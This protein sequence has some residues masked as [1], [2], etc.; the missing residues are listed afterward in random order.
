MEQQAID[1]VHR[2]G[3]R[4]PVTVTRLIAKDSIEE[5]I[6]KIQEKKKALAQGALGE[7][8][9]TQ[10]MNKLLVNDLGELFSASPAESAAALIRSMQGIPPNVGAP[11][12]GTQGQERASSQAVELIGSLKNEI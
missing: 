9:I 8:S 6:L 12:Q 5:R 1:R 10:T 3:Q 7:M 11:F 2:Y 4:S